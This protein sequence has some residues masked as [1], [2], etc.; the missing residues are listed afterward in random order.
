LK[1]PSPRQ[2]IPVGKFFLDRGKITE[3]QLELALKHRA[4][5]GLKLGQ[6]LVELGFV[7]EAD[8]V[9]ALRYQAR[10]ACIHLTSGIVEAKVAAK[11]GEAVSRRLRA[12]ALNQIAGHTTVALQDPTDAEALTE[13]SHLLGTRIFPVYGEPSAIARSI[14]QVFGPDK[15]A[16]RATPAKAAPVTA[17]PAAQAP[18]APAAESTNTSVATEAKTAAPDERAVV[19]FIRGLLMKGLEEGV[20]AI[21]VEPRKDALLVRFRSDGVL[22]EHARQPG[23]WNEVALACIKGL[24]KLPAE[25][26]EVPRESSIALVFKKRQVEVGVRL[27]PAACGESIVLEL[28]DA[29]RFIALDELGLTAEQRTDVEPLLA[30]G[31]GLLL[32]GGP[33]GSGRS[34]TLYGLLEHMSGKDLKCIALDVDPGFLFED[35]MQVH[36]NARAGLDF[37]AGVAAALRQDPDL[38]MVG[39]LDSSRT[40]GA[41]LTSALAGRTILTSLRTQN[42]LEVLTKLQRLGLEPFLLAEALRGVVAQRPVRAICPDC[43]TR[44]VPDSELRSRFGLAKE[45]A[46]YFEG[47]GCKACHG[48]GYRGIVRL[49]EVLPMT[50]GLS[51]EL[52][53]GSSAEVL[54]RVAREEGFLG[55]REHGLACARAGTT[56][57]REVLNVLGGS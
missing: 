8:M 50:S 1:S 55:L 12:I 5:F 34:T 38:L 19:E 10:F 52:E 17:A 41:L 24:A 4:E 7:S 56:T 11:V 51:G 48:T 25:T 14:E 21:H 53:K 57:L 28:N 47:E 16:R 49:F 33:A 6:S 36:V 22:R 31:G 2:P 9:E 46:A 15:N 44:S 13:L 37:G 35:V 54:A 43:K 18:P 39:E 42:A 27:V 30:P 3:K 29:R 23:A 32:V 26:G 20:S 45:G 40:A